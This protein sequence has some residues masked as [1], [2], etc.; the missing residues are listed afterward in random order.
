MLVVVADIVFVDELLE[1]G[2]NG[3]G[4]DMGIDHTRLNADEGKRMY[5]DRTKE[6][7]SAVDNLILCRIVVS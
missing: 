7:Y 5:L 6:S 1:F 3:G 2:C 4:M